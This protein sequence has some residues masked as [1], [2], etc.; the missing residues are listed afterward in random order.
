MSSPGSTLFSIHHYLKTIS[1]RI[2]E[3]VQEQQKNP[4]ELSSSEMEMVQKA[5]D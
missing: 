2:G 4:I 3:F 1:S 5:G